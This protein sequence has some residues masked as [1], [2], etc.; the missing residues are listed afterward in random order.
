MQGIVNNAVYLNYFEHARHEYLHSIGLD[1][2]ALLLQNIVLVATRVEVDYKRSLKSGDIFSVTVNIE[3]SS[4]IRYVFEQTI[5]IED[6][7]MANAKT[8]VVS[9]N[10]HGKPT[11]FPILEKI[12]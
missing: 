5:M 11:R 10:E 12:S 4:P 8:Y 1:F 9:L 6:K 7:V 3:K 2:K